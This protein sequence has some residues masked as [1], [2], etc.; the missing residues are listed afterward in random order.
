MKANNSNNFFTCQCTPLDNSGK[1]PESQTYITNT[2]L[3]SIKFENKDTINI[4][5]SLSVGKAH[6]LENISIR[7]LKIDD[8]AIVEPVSILFN[9]SLNQS[10]FLDIWKRSSIY[11]IHQRDDKQIISSYRPVSL[12]PICGKIFERLFFNSL[13]EYVEENI[14][15]VFGLTIYV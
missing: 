1:I 10:I 15:L 6:G 12:L 9:D 4:I 2:D 7:L 13:Y 11:P 14:N 5:I 8:S 3:S